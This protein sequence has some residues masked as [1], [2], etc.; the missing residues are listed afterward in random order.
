MARRS[1]LRTCLVPHAGSRRMGALSRRP[2][3]LDFSLGLDLGGRRSVGL[4]AVSLRTLGDGRRP[5]GLGC[6]TGGRCAGLR[7]RA[8]GLPWNRR[9]RIRRQCGMVP[10]GP[11]GS[12][13]AVVHR[14]PGVHQPDQ[15]QQ[16][17]SQHGKHHQRLQHN[18]RQPDYQH[19]QCH[20]REPECSGRGHCGS[21]ARLRQRTARGQSSRCR[22]RA[23]DGFGA[24]EFEGFRG[25]LTR[26]RAGSEGKQRGTGSGAA[27]RRGSPTGG[28]Q[29]DTAS[30]ARAVRQTAAG[31][32]S[33]SG[34]A[35]GAARSADLAS[36]EHSGRATH[37]QTGAS[38]EAGNAEPCAERA[39]SQGIRKTGSACEC[40][41]C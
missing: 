38:R 41:A 16:H 35:P 37:G 8:G 39:T 9:H 29:S 10:A 7:A 2:L 32:G 22:E 12:L 27:G 28:R 15:R 17:P 13:R 19:R 20:L 34:T 14:E 33:A 30:A 25:A 5:L 26:E 23:G 31:L 1:Q 4:C 18:H 24:G 3:G 6:W 11:A 40:T 21:A 36:G